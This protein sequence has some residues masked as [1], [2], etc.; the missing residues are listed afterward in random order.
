MTLITTIAQVATLLAAAYFGQYLVTG[1]I[2]YASSRLARIAAHKRF[3][4]EQMEFLE[5]ICEALRNGDHQRARDLRRAVD[6]RAQDH[7]K[8]L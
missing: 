4:Q 6:Q 1:S 2:A 5:P 7:M 8:S 3:Q